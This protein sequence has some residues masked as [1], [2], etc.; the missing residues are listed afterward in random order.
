MASDSKTS[1]NSSI[2]T[3]VILT[4]V[5]VITAVLA[6]FAAYNYLAEKNDRYKTLNLTAQ[7]SAERLAASLKVPLWDLDNEAIDKSLES[8]MRDPNMIAIVLL[9][10]DG[11]AVYAAKERSSTWAIVDASNALISAGSTQ[12]IDNSDIVKKLNIAYKEGENI[13]TVELY[14]TASFVDQQLKLSL[15][16]IIAAVLLLDIVIFFVLLILLRSLIFQ[17]IRNLSDAVEKMSHGETDVEIDTD[18]NDEIGSLAQS[19]QRMQ[20]SLR[21]TMQRLKQKSKH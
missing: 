8:E 16:R 11:K 3:K 13:G 15:Y 6:V 14:V 4:P 7:I 12:A 5:I 2:Q 17:P 19:F 21:Y 1:S 18:R 20:V 10:R 9:D